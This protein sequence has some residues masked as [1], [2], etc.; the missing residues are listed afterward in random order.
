MTPARWV[1]AGGLGLSLLMMIL[2]ANGTTSMGVFIAW[3]ILLVAGLGIFVAA[4]KVDE[5]ARLR[6]LAEERRQ[7]LGR[8]ER[9]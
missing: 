3:G 8:D 9:Q 2:L 5:E 4:R 7:R 6:V 1:Q